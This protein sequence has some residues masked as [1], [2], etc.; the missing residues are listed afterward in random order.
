MADPQLSEYVKTQLAAGV[1]PEGVRKALLD[2]GWQEADVAQ[3]MG[4]PA[5]AASP[6][7][8]APTAAIAAGHPSKLPFII[9][10]LIVLLG[11]GGAGAYFLGFFEPRP[12][13]VV[14][15]M[16]LAVNDAKSWKISGL[17]NVDAEQKVETK[18]AGLAAVSGT[19]VFNFD[20]EAGVIKAKF[21]VPAE[22]SS[23]TRDA[24]NKKLSGVL[25]LFGSQETGAQADLGLEVRQINKAL[26]IKLTDAPNIGFIS[27]EPLENQWVAFD[28]S[29]DLLGVAGSM[30]EGGKENEEKKKELTAD[31]KEKIR[32]AVST[33]KVL[34][35]KDALASEKIAGRKAYHYR[36]AVDKVAAEKMVKEID[37]IAGLEQAQVDAQSQRLSRIYSDLPDA[38]IEVW[39]DQK[40]FLPRKAKF[41][42]KEETF[43]EGGAK[44]TIDLT[45]EFSRWNE[46]IGIETPTDAK[47]FQELLGVL[48]GGMMGGA[49]DGEGPIAESREQSRDAKRIAD[50][51]QIQTALEI[52]YSETQQYPVA[53]KPVELGSGAA[54]TT[55]LC[56]KDSK[57]V[58]QN[59]TAGCS[60]TGFTYM[61][62][63]PSNPE[64]GGQAYTYSSKDGKSYQL[65][66][67]VEG[68]I[69]TFQP[70][71]LCANENGIVTG[72]TC[73][74]TQA[75]V[76][77][78]PGHAQTFS[79][80]KVQQ[81]VEAISAYREK[82]G[83]FPASLWDVVPAGTKKEDVDIDLD[84]IDYGASDNGTKIELNISYL[85]ESG[86]EV[87]VSLNECGFGHDETCS[88]S[89]FGDTDKD[90]LPTASEF[91]YG[92]DPAK[93]DTDGDGFKDGDE[94]KSGYDPNGTGKL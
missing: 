86:R 9:I 70:G 94:V 81:I 92:S 47:P 18:S 53:V 72:D 57:P 8:T 36:V 38:D 91:L 15:K 14:Q 51:R 75:D 76:A 71:T 90:G 78:L 2:Q 24:A 34:I 59:G 6:L 7:Y 41:V 1:K 49:L 55:T 27:L 60:E 39:I 19:P 35:I 25:K 84:A 65:V 63:V 32:Q 33:A 4:A 82:N 67:A 16:L 62:L 85:E 13:E 10:G 12:E 22:A 87:S 37:S 28:S 26:Y 23:D 54:K 11:G 43:R 88:D 5:M 46:D 89:S 74:K 21:K 48:M 29:E 40:D 56:N 61:S 42:F 20:E 93:A 31:Q 66:F 80:R 69:S 3:A 79:Y 44:G 17:G 77:P 45:L 30:G 73:A 64:P 50:I 68:E 58:W 52:G 83:K